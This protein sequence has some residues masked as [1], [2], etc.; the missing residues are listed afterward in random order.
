MAKCPFCDHP[1]PSNATQCAE[2]RA[3]LRTITSREPTSTPLIPAPEPDSLEAELLEL[4]RGQK[5]LLAV[6]LYRER[7]GVGIAEAKG[8]IEELRARHGIA[9][10]DLDSE[11]SDAIAASEPHGVEAEILELMRGRKKIEAIKLYRQ[12]SGVG[13]KEAKDFV[14]ALAAKHGVVAASRG[15]CAAIVLLM[16]LAGS[17]ATGAAWILAVS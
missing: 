16:V 5:R 14:E 11:L 12:R 3:P 15:G 9:C 1:N 7:T 6:K 2:C 8:F 17:A 13:L 10:G 4:I